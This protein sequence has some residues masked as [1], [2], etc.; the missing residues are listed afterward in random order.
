MCLWGFR[1]GL[2]QPGLFTSKDRIKFGT[3]SR[4]LE[5][6]VAGPFCLLVFVLGLSVPVNNYFFSHVGTEPTLPE[7]NQYCRELMCLAQG[8]ITMTPVGIVPR[9]SRFGVRLSTTTPP[10]SPGPFCSQGA[11]ENWKTIEGNRGLLGENTLGFRK[12][13]ARKRILGSYEERSFFF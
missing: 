6:S 5:S 10:R 7:F 9:T 3:L 11:W 12:L 13:G 4:V 1:P 2:R 8:Q